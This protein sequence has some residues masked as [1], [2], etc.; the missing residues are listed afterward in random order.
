ML[1]QREVKVYGRIAYELSYV[2][3]ESNPNLTHK[4]IPSVVRGID[5][6]FM[7][8]NGA[9]V[10]SFWADDKNYALDLDRF[11]LFLRSITY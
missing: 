7:N 6:I 8:G 1:D 4:N 9:L 5:Y 10:V 2:Y 11:L 3:V